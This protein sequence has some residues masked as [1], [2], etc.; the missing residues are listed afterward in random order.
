MQALRQGFREPV[1]QGLQHDG[2]VVVVVLLELAQFPLHAEAGGHGEG[3]DMVP[4][5]GLLRG[6]EICQRKIRLPGRFLR[7]LPETVEHGQQSPAVPVRIHLDIVIADGVGREQAEHGAGAE[8]LLPDDVIKHRAGV[9]ME[10]ARLLT[11]GCIVEDAREAP[12][13]LPGEE[14]RGPVDVTAQFGQGIILEYPDT[15]QR[16]FRGFVILPVHR[17]AVVPGLGQRQ[18][19]YP[20][21]PVLVPF[22][23]YGVLL[24]HLPAQAHL[25]VRAEQALGYPHGAGCILHVHHRFGVTRVDFHRSV[26]ARGGGAADEQ[27]DIEFSPLHLRRHVHHLVQ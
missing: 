27:G 13:Q 20:G 19:F 8:P 16:R 4:F 18:P 26:G 17:Q 12:G 11:H 24:L 9:G 7:L 14:K 2:P 15:R 3:A 1:G 23:Q 6:N 5:P 25:Q 10:F 21:L 22:P